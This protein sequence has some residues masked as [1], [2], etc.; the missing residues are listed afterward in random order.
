[1]DITFIYI[2]IF[3]TLNMK[4]I[5]KKRSIKIYKIKETTIF[6]ISKLK[7]TSRIIKKKQ[8]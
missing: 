2:Y 7:F 4:G 5:E 8:K 3:F 6:F 1:M